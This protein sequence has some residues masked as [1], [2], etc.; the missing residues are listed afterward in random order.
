MVRAARGA[1]P[2]SVALWRTLV[3]AA[4]GLAPQRSA[5]PER[6][7]WRTASA[8]SY[9]APLPAADPLQFG[10][11]YQLPPFGRGN[12]LD[13]LF[14]TPVARL[15]VDR[16]DAALAALEDEDIPAWAAPART[17]ERVADDQHDLWVASGRLD[18]GQDVLMRVL[19]G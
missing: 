11:A 2:R 9:E 6:S 19:A 16:V 15:P 7:P 10:R 12:G 18:E 17:A 14:W 4:L 13:A 3:T 5:A 8:S 1:A